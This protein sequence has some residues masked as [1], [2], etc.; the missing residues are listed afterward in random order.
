MRVTL[1]WVARAMGLPPQFWAWLLT[2]PEIENLN[3]GDPC[4]TSI[5]F[6]QPMQ[7]AGKHSRPSASKRQPRNASEDGWRKKQNKLIKRE[8]ILRYYRHLHRP[9]FEFM[10]LG[11]TYT[12]GSQ[13]ALSWLSVG[14]TVGSQLALQFSSVFVNFTENKEYISLL[15]AVPLPPIL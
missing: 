2:P 8:D 6:I 3:S 15:K 10:Q 12:V 13:L 7:S 9:M 11:L 5:G 14:S 4:V 1:T